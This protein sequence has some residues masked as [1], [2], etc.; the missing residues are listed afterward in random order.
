VLTRSY[1]CTLIRADAGQLAMVCWA[2]PG[3]WE[4]RNRRAGG[5]NSLRERSKLGDWLCFVSRSLK[6]GYHS[7]ILHFFKL[8]F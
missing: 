6:N 4:E 8:I 3:A 2:A 5:L 7:L 1:R